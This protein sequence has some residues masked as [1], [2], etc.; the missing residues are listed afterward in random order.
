MSGPLSSKGLLKRYP[1]L[2]TCD[3]NALQIALDMMESHPV[4][5]NNLR[6]KLG[7][8]RD[9]ILMVQDY[10]WS[11]Q[12]KLSEHALYM[13]QLAR[14]DTLL[15]SLWNYVT[16]DKVLYSENRVLD[17]VITLLKEATDLAGLR[18]TKIETEVRVINEQQAEAIATFAGRAFDHVL[19]KVRP[20]L[21]KKGQ[22]EVDK[23]IEK[24]MLEAC[25][26]NASVL[27]EPKALIAI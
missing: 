13:Q 26:L 22:A 4:L 6:K 24:W 15:S 12:P 8:D 23:N 14:L 18:K 27:E 5:P 25:E 20:L 17:N 3:P 7:L 21:T 10:Y 11:N 1:T 9:Q 19:T 2:S 16:S